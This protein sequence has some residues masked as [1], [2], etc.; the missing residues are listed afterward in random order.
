MKLNSRKT[1]AL[2]AF[3]AYEQ[4]IRKQIITDNALP[5]DVHA[6]IYQKEGYDL[7]EKY[8]K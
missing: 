4:E 2:T 3:Y 6:T 8:T 1:H 7:D 5:F